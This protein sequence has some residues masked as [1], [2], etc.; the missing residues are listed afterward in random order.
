MIRHVFLGALLGGRERVDGIELEDGKLS[1]CPGE[2]KTWDEL[3]TVWVESRRHTE[4]PLGRSSWWDLVLIGKGQ[5]WQG[6]RC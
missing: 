3:V 5:G 2:M 4:R 6:V 1:D